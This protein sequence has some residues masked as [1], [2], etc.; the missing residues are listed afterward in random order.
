MD[1]QLS[2]AEHAGPAVLVCDLDGTI[3]FDGQVPAVEAA[4]LRAWTEAGNLLVLNTGKSV[5]A[6]RRVWHAG[7]PRPDYVIAFTGAV[8]TDGDLVPLSVTAHDPALFPEVF[9]TVREERL[10]LY[11]STMERDYE[12]FNR[13]GTHSMILPA[14]EP[15]D[16]AWVATQQLFGIPLLVPGDDDRSRL[17]DSLAEL[18]G[19][20]AVVH[21][22]QIFLDI[23][24]A[25]ATKGLGLRHLLT[26]LLPAHGPIWTI[27]DSWN[28]LSMHAEADHP[29]ALTHSP[30]E[31]RDACEIAVPS[32]HALIE[33]ILAGR[34]S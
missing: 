13:A 24:P 10:A 6:T 32:T 4:A 5:D 1:P 20:R 3:V 30:A 27:G 18:T 26:E 25:G 9:R 33:Q 12:V 14:F 22:N 28:D 15:A 29:I 34:L 17:A 31:V 23:V 19:D 2:S 7:L 11:A 8:I 21:R 16:A